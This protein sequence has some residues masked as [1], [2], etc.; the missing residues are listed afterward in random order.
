MF[1]TV[2]PVWGLSYDTS[3]GNVSIPITVN[4]VT[5]GAQRFRRIF[6]K[7]ILNQIQAAQTPAPLFFLMTALITVIIGVKPCQ[8]RDQ[9]THR[10]RVMLI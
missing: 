10:Q 1:S 7:I 6:T 4:L 5:A 2:I 3:S 8:L 9:T